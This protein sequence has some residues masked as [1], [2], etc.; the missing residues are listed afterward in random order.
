MAATLEES[1]AYEERLAELY[2]LF[3]KRHPRDEA[4]WSELAVEEEHHAAILRSLGVWVAIGADVA[5]VVAPSLP[6]LKKSN[7]VLSRVLERA[8]KEP[9]TRSDAFNIALNL[10]RTAS[11][12]HFQK[13]MVGKAGGNDKL[14]GA[15]RR[16]CAFD[17]DHLKRIRAMMKTAGIKIADEVGA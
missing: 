9:V 13:T 8:R 15:M 6:K 17:K 11:E 4:F 7:A 1:V 10:E 16:L 14:A 3:A 5:H 2:R 12:A